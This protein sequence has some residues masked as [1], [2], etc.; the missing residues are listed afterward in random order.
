MSGLLGNYLR[1][2]NDL[3]NIKVFQKNKDDVHELH[4]DAL[5][6]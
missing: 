6:W 5:C 4:S 2:T 3:R 1:N